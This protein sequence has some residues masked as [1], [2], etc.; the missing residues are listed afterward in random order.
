MVSQLNGNVK[1]G[2]DFDDSF[3]FHMVILISYGCIFFEIYICCINSI[4]RILLKTC[5]YVM[6]QSCWEGMGG[7]L[8][9]P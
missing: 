8:V 2:F 3:S 6:S 5:W 9:S 7:I 4:N 1:D